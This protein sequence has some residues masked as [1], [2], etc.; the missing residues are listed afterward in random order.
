VELADTF[1]SMLGRLDTAFTAQKEFVANASHELRTPLTIIRTEVDVAL[2]DP[3]VSPEELQE[4]GSAITE[5]VDR[6][7][8]LIDGLLVLASADGRPTLSDLDLAEVAADEVHLSS[9]DADALGLRLELAA[10]GQANR[11]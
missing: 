5:A 10:A 2:S 4:M 6:S 3:D 7:E 11:P 1:D 9:G 8:G